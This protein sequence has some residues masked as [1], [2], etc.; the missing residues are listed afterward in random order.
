MDNTP[1]KLRALTK[2]AAELD[3]SRR[4]VDRRRRDDPAFPRV[5]TIRGRTYVESSAWEKYKADLIQRA[6]AEPELGAVAKRRAKAKGLK[7]ASSA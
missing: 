6:L 5:I 3:T 4:T 2:L 7:E 1:T